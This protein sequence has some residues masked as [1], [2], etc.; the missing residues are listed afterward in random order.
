M[1]ERA[2]RVL[3]YDKIRKKLASHATSGPGRQKCMDLEPSSDIGEIRR[4]QQETTD[5]VSRLLRKGSISF[6]NTRNIGPSLK[7]LEVGSAL[8]MTELLNIAGLLENAAR[9]K[10]YGRHENN[11]T[12][13]DKW[14]FR[15]KRSVPVARRA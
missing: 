14:D 11:D 6:G 13:T 2:L 8:S 15:N 1:N 10:S 3:E 5:A 9:V 7:R 4:L 12:G